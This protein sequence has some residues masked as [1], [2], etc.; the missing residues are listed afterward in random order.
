M[1]RGTISRRDI[2]K[3]VSAAC[4][5]LPAPQL[6]A[7]AN[8]KDQVGQSD[9]LSQLFGGPFSLVAHTGK[10]VTN[11]DFDGRYLLIFFGYTGCPDVCPIG[12][13]VMTQAL[14]MLG[15]SAETIQPLFI[16]V[17]PERDT[18]EQLAKYVKSFHPRLIGLS[19]TEAQIN[20]VAKAYKV[21]RRKVLTGDQAHNEYVIDHGS[22]TYF[23]GRDGK[24]LTLIPYNAT[25]ERMAQVLKT[26]V[27]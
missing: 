5:V 25:A 21:H 8:V 23:M 1:T 20:D 17:D 6:Y 16:T 3:L 22:L 13:T 9:R 27:S 10:P 24:F 15:A 2:L 12:L 4:A 7:G 26:Y 11:A 18:P 19:G 14:D